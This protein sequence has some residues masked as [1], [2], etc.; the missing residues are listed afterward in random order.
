[1]E[2]KLG[3]SI[4]ELQ[5]GEKASFSKTITETDIYNYAG[6]AGDFNPMHVNEEYAKTTRFKRR[7][8]HGGV[9]TCLI[10]PVLGTMLPG[11]GTVALEQ[12][13]RFK[14]PVFIG[15]TIT[16]IAEVIDRNVE[17]NIAVLK[18][19]WQ[20]QRGEIVVEGEAKVMPPK[21]R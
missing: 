6:I 12:T 5:L 16:A 17:K 4:D 10:G 1:M 21:K 18:L 15:D 14:A 13:L 9:I 2:F 19:I 3:K 11:L 8:A 7:V 20:N